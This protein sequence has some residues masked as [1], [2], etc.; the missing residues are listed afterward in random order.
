MNL[1]YLTIH[2][3]HQLLKDREVSSVELTK[4]MLERISAT[5]DKVHSFVT[6]TG[7]LPRMVSKKTIHVSNSSSRYSSL[8]QDIAFCAWFRKWSKRRSMW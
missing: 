4:A 3:A 7:D 1:H 8:N 6:V 5:E 2:Q